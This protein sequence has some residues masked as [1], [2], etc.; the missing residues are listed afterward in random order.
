MQDSH[1]LVDLQRARHIV[2]E[3]GYRGSSVLAPLCH[4]ICVEPH[5][6]LFHFPLSS[7]A[8][9][10]FITYQDKLIDGQ[11][12]IFNILQL[13][14]S[15]VPACFHLFSVTGHSMESIPS[16]PVVKRPGE[17]LSLSCRGSCFTFSCCSMYGIRQQA[18]KKLE[19]IGEGYSDSRRGK[20]VSSLS[21]H[22]EIDQRQQQRQQHDISESLRSLER[23]WHF[24]P[25]TRGLCCV[26]LCER[27]T[28]V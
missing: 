6:S 19:W 8:A 17:T 20:Y 4:N 26:L 24:H 1:L 2:L 14:V 3:V 23:I 10:Y 7:C 13:Y 11:L 9:Y 28:V 27:Q 25:K 12:M 21:G 22:I 16:N 15:L 5:W 18:E